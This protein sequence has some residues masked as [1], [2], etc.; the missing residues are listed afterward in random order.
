M[1]SECVPSILWDCSHWSAFY[2]CDKHLREMHESGR[3]YLVHSVGVVRWWLSSFRHCGSMRRQSR[4]AVEAYGRREGAMGKDNGVEERGD[5]IKLWIHHWWISLPTIQSLPKSFICE[6]CIRHQALNIQTR[7]EH[8]HPNHNSFWWVSASFLY[9]YILET[10]SQRLMYR[11]Q[12]L[13][14]W[15][16]TQLHQTAS[17]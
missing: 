17:F 10:E 12:K 13:Y 15:P 6:H 14:Y 9:K 11:K 16:T 5:D 3:L 7:G 1:V 4:M 8:L 2:C